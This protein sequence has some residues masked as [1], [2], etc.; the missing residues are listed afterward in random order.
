M[1]TIALPIETKVR[2][3]DG[4]TWLALHLVRGG[5]RVVLGPHGALAANIGALAPDVYVLNSA[6]A[7]YRPLAARLKRAG[8]RVAVLDTEGGL[9]RSRDAYATRLD[10]E[11][12]EEVDHFLAWGPDPASIVRETMG[13]RPG[14]EVAVTGHPTFDLLRSPA[15]ELFEPEAADIRREFGGR[16]V[17]LNTNFGYA[18]PFTRTT[19]NQRTETA[20]RRRMEELL[21]GRLLELTTRLARSYPSTQIVL[22]PHPSEDH[23]MYRRAFA[24]ITNVH[25]HHRGPVSPWL[26]ACAVLVH[27][28]CTTGVEA[29]LMGRPVLAYCPTPYH[30]EEFSVANCVSEKVG[31]DDAL[32]ARVG[33]HLH[34]SDDRRVELAGDRRAFLARYIANTDFSAAE[35]ITS[36][37]L[38]GQSSTI[39]ART[40]PRSLALR[41]F[42]ALFG[43]SGLDRVRALRGREARTQLAYVRQKLP[44]LW[45]SELEERI[46]RMG[47][48]D[49]TLGAARVRKVVGV[50]H[51]FVVEPA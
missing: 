40:D 20:E 46:A 38:S 8:G 34:R 4:K 26:K 3:L 32:I 33:E 21:L 15:D 11:L 22:R 51:T 41:G 19:V 37:F 2:E 25:V 39:G 17:L 28:V 29:A 9:Y 48:I 45:R 31:E 24:G 5:A 16:F 27:N 47:R 43:E 30:V 7:M 1:R 44:G 50:E 36:V 42:I 14:A 10:V 49:P 18:N 13:T 12:L 23:D 6:D 35:R